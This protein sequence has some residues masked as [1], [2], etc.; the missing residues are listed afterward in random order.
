MP[1]RTRLRRTHIRVLL[2]VLVLGLGAATLALNLPRG[3]AAK[4]PDPFASGMLTRLFPD[5]DLAAVD[6]PTR[7]A[8]RRAD[9]DAARYLAA[10]PVRDDSAFLSFAVTHVGPPP[11]RA[12]SRRELAALHRIG[13]HRTPGGKR[14][15]LWLE[16]V[17]KK[18]VWKLYLKQYRQQAPAAD[19][20]RLKAELKAT[21]ALS[22]RLT[23]LA[24]RHY[25]RTSPYQVDPSL[26]GL[27]QKRFSGA[28]KVSY[29]SKHSVIA[30]TAEGFLDRLDP[31][32]D[33][34]YRWMA[35]EIDF[36]RL[37]GAGHYPSDLAAGAYL[38]RL[39]ARY[40]LALGPRA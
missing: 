8:A 13:A 6:G 36:S 35:D 32:R 33:A 37:Y 39:V 23:D 24:K 16:Q 5:R 3:E 38:G 18:D 4:K 15:A 12:A 27:N 30:F 20:K 29:P 31:H 17:G 22:K 26:R 11:G 10:H 25:A 40:E 7:A 28:R 9:R 1:D 14:A 21:I 34:E 2:V 19:G